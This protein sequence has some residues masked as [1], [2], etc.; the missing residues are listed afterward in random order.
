MT[1]DASSATSYCNLL[2]LH[3]KTGKEM[4]LDL[5]TGAGVCGEGLCQFASDKS[6]S[7]FWRFDRVEDGKAGE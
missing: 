2:V 7:Q 4:S 1:D 6:A 5:G 3:S